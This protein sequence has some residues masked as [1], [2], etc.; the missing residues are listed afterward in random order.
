[1]FEDTLSRLR[2][3]PSQLCDLDRKPAAGHVAWLVGH[4]WPKGSPDPIAGRLCFHAADEDAAL[5]A[6]RA[7]NPA[8]AITTCERAPHLDGVF[9]GHR[10]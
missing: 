6:A 7:A 9:W 1:M 5:T 3:R 4:A 8:C 10:T 2:Q